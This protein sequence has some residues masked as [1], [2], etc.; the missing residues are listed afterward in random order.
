MGGGPAGGDAADAADGAS[1]AYESSAFL[2]AE[3]DAAH[4]S[5]MYELEDLLGAQRRLRMAIELGNSLIS[6]GQFSLACGILSRVL[7]D[8]GLCTNH[9]MDFYTGVDAE[10]LARLRVACVR[11]AHACGDW[12]VAHSQL[13]M[14]CLR[15]PFAELNWAL[16]SAVA[17]R[18]RQRGYDER[19][20]LRLLMR[21]P[22]SALIALSVAHHC[23]LSR[24]FKIALSEYTR[25]HE[26]Y[27]KEPL[28][29]L[30]VAVAPTQ[31]VMSR[32]N[33]DPGPSVLLAFGWLSAYADLRDEQE[34]AYNT[35]RTYHHLG[36]SHL[37]VSSYQKVLQ[38]SARRAAERE[39]QRE[40]Q[41]EAQREARQ[42]QHSSGE[43]A[44]GTSAGGHAADGDAA[45]RKQQQEEEEAAAAAQDVAREAMHNLARICCASGSR[46]LARQL[47]RSMPV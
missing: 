35:A 40:A 15:A 10:E 21:E 16:Y 7:A 28:L 38:I 6:L 3:D 14:L 13:R 18:A 29:L 31:L 24:S 41:W 46:D 4:S 2:D 19:W 44:A 26:R 36:L 8:V 45:E 43:G 30:C 1:L 22:S 25:L 5:P 12:D 39:A 42:P 20:L 9:K 11:A 23:L 37:A 33:R 17:G 32:A 47:V 27:P 34:A